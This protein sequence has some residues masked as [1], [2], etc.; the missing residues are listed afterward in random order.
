MMKKFYPKLCLFAIALIALSLSSCKKEGLIGPQGSQGVPGVTGST[1]PNL[2][3]NITGFV[4]L[5]DQ[6]GTRIF[7]N[8]NKVSVSIDNTTIS[9]KTD[10]TGKYTFN[11][12]TTGIYTITSSDSL[13]G[14]EKAPQQQFV[15]GG[16]INKD[17]KLS[18]IPIFTLATCVAI[19]TVPGGVNYVK[20]RG[21]V[22]ATD[23]KS[24]EFVAFV[25]SSTSVS[26]APANY[27]LIYNA[28]IKANA[29]GFSVSIPATDLYGAGFTSGSSVY[30]AVYPA[31]A[32]F[33]TS[34]FWE[35]YTT[36]RNYYTAI[37]STPIF[38]SALV[39]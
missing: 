15:G 10:S 7:T 3:G 29:T 4:W 13:Y 35:D 28:T 26:S 14:M 39:P 8:L 21:T 38:C 37:G 9:V 23:T 25:S 1:G 17:F 27:L 5:Y 24:R 22:T 32:N 33:N 6:Y 30:F 20:V 36:G 12:L 34:S 2:S 11:S 16:N 31:A 18:Q 19:D